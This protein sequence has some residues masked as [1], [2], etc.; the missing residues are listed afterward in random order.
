MR[1]A[2][3][4]GGRHLHTWNDLLGVFPGVVGVKTGHT[5]D[6]GWC[7]VAAVRGPGVTIYAMILGS[8]TARTERRPRRA[9]CA[10]G[11][12]AVPRRLGRS[13]RAAPTR[14]PRR[15]TGAAQSRSSPRKPLV[16]AVRVGR[17][18]VERI[19]APAGVAPAGARG[20][21]RSGGSRSGRGGGCSARRRSWPRRS[22]RSRASADGY[23]GTSAR[24][25]HNAG[26]VSSHDRH[27]HPQRRGRPHAH[28]AELPARPPAPGERQP[29]ACRR[30]GHQR[31]PR[32]EAARRAGDR[33]R[34][35][36]RPHGRPDRRGARPPRRSST[37]SSASATS[38][39]PRPRSS[40]RPPAR[41]PRST[42]GGRTPSRRS[43][44]ILLDK[45]HYLANGAQTVVFSGSLPRG[46]EDDFYAEAIRDLNRRGVQTVL[47]SE[48]EPLRL[49]TS[50]PSRSSSRRTSARP[51][52]SSARSSTRRRTSSSALDSIAELGARNVLITQ[53][54]GCFALFRE[55]REVRRFRC[56]A[57]RVEPV[58]SV[59]SGDVLLAGFLAARHRRQPIEE[60]LRRQ[61]R[62][63]TASTL[64]LGAGRFDPREASRVAAA[65]RSS[66]SSPSRTDRRRPRLIRSTAS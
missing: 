57:P 36:R 10:W 13:R 20:R 12:L 31:R 39:A 33:H 58:S 7:E 41:T 16:R 64:E 32:A 61:S 26:W 62:R 2:T 1:D 19:V 52:A 65:S 53:E 43:S 4:A 47:D 51:R 63:G 37:T 28:G 46:V 3:I 9:A 56:V 59:G 11:R 24:T 34:P 60:A 45:L 55:E 48:G 27:R 17:P 18:L 14:G 21:A 35:R 15:R 49:G 44:T 30:Q 38:R 8:P 40:T 22:S 50:A 66:S 25:V 42:N 5:N 29:D 23:G 54:T 6:A